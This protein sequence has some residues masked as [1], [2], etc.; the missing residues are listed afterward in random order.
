MPQNQKNHV[1]DPLQAFSKKA[2][3]YHNRPRYPRQLL[4]L[5]IKECG[6]KP[7][8]VI[9]DIGSGT[10]FLTRLLLTMG[11]KVFAVEP[12]EEMRCIAENDLVD[13][14]GFI[15][16]KGKAEKI[17]LPAETVDVVAVGQALHWFEIAAARSEFLRIL[18]PGGWIVVVDNV[19]NNDASSFMLSYQKFRDQFFT[20]L[21]T[22]AD[23]PEKIVRLFKQVNYQRYSISNPFRCDESVFRAGILSS[24]TAPLPG[25][26]GF[27]EFEAAL[28]LLFTQFQSDEKVEVL[29]DTVVWMGKLK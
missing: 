18:R 3:Y 4:D 29:F 2:V 12:N 21:G 28:H 23:P 15:S 19:M 5:L 13:F 16:L 20:D 6:L 1:I 25:S 24:A 27:A 26:E 14:P 22:A 10:G 7:E 8:S 11:N 9:A 17:P